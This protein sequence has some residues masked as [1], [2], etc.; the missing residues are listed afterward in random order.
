M[1]N[2]TIATANYTFDSWK[3]VNLSSDVTMT[4]R[5][6][7][8]GSFS[9]GNTTTDSFNDRQDELPQHNVTITKGFWIADS[10]CTQAQWNI[11]M[12]NNPSFNNR[13]APDF[14]T[15]LLRPVENVSWND[16]QNF[17]TT[18]NNKNLGIG[19]FRLP[20]E[21]E[22]EY[23]CR[24]G[25]TTPYYTGYDIDHYDLV[26]IRNHDWYYS[27]FDDYHY[28]RQI[29]TKIEN[30]WGLY[31]MGGNV[32]EWCNDWYYSQYYTTS[33]VTN[34]I[35][36]VSGSEKVVRGSSAWESS[37]DGRSANRDREDPTYKTKD[38]GFRVVIEI[39]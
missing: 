31:D 22:W 34:P 38:L 3:I 8:P 14:I 4:F 27:M 12:G 18:M 28:T 13:I 1:S 39:Q 23:S 32:R 30:P 6:I 37:S 5:W 21:A 9:M 11:I 2:S 7:E 25:T 10:E 17:M 35:G 33:S 19:I 24:A 20:T 36:P 26:E 15:N 29:R 16:C